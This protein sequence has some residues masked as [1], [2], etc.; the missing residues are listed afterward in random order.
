[1]SNEFNKHGLSRNIPPNIKAKIRQNDGYGC[2]KCG[3]I[4]IQY[5]HI[6]PLFCDAE[7]HDADKITLLCAG[8][9][10]ESTGKRL[11]KRII[12]LLKKDPYCKRSGFTRS[13]RFYPNPEQMIIQ[14]GNSTFSNTDIAITIHG[15]P[16]IWV[17]KD[18]SDPYSPLLYNAIFMDSNGKKIGYL[19]NNEFVGIVGSCDF[20][21]ISNRIEVRSKKGEINLIL[22]IKGDGFVNI[23]RLFFKYKNNTFKL[24][25]DGSIQINENQRIGEIDIDNCLG[26]LKLMNSPSTRNPYNFLTASIYF[27]KALK[28]SDI[29]GNLCGY[30]LNSEI[31]DLKFNSVGSIDGNKVYNLF[32]EYIGNIFKNNNSYIHIVME[33]FEYPDQEPIWISP[34]NKKIFF[35]QQQILIDTSYRLF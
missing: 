24:N 7:I 11:P 9:H 30:I 1:M 17:T 12:N 23:K 5:E 13:N 29:F 10:D 18:Y 14:I 34:R 15:K 33:E 32:N 3:N 22:E 35:F 26:G 25:K 20:Q 27:I 19:N 4:F 28:V 6:E 8:C 31:F 2:V 21:A 16:I